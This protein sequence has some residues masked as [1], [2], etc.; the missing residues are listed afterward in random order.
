MLTNLV[1]AATAFTAPVAHR[2]SVRSSVNMFGA[3][4]CGRCP[5]GVRD[6]VRG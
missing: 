3:R 1:L 5:P 6:I 4:S 2:A